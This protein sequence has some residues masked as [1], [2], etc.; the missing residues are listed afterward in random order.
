MGFLSKLFKPITDFLGDMVGFL[1]GVDFDDIENQAPAVLVNKQS[2]VAAL[3]VI[4][5]RRK[6]GGVRVYIGTG[7]SKNKYLYICLALCE[8]EIEAIESV[9]I[10][11]RLIQFDR[12]GSVFTSRNDSFYKNKIKMQKFLGTDTGKVQHATQTYSSILAEQSEWTTS[13]KLKGVAYL[14]LRVQHDSD[15]HGGIPDIKCIVKGRKVYDPRDSTTSYTNNP[16]LCLRDYLTNTRYGKGLPASAIDD[17]TGRAGFQTAADS[18]DDASYTVTPFFGAGTT[19]HL[20]ECNARLDTNKTIFSNVKEM[21][22]GMRGLMPY[23]EGKYGLIID[24]GYTP[25]ANTF[26]LTPDNITSQITVQQSGKGKR[27]NRV[28]V[29]FPNPSA[30]WQQDSVMFPEK[31]TDSNS[32]YLTFLSEDNNEELVKEVQC[33]TITSIYAARELA[34]IICLASRKNVNAVKITATSEALNIAVGD[35]VRLEHPSFGWTGAARQLMRVSNLQMQDDGEVG[36]SLVEHNNSIYGFTQGSMEPDNLESTFS[37]IFDID[38]PTGLALTETTVVGGDGSLQPAITASWTAADD[39]FVQDYEIQWKQSADSAYQ[40]AFTTETQYEIAPVQV[41]IAAPITYDVR[42]RSINTAN[43]KSDFASS[44]QQVDGDDGDPSPV[45][46]VTFTRGLKNITLEWTN[47]TDSD[48]SYVQIYISSTLTKPASPSAQVR[49]TEYVY[50]AQ[51]SEGKGTTKYFWLEAVDFSGNVSTTVGPEQEIIQLPKSEEID[52]DVSEAL[53]INVFKYPY[54]SVPASTPNTF[55]EFAIP[56]PENAVSKYASLNGKIKYIPSTSLDD[57]ILVVEFQRKSKGATSGASLGNVVASGTT[58]VPYTHYLEIS[59]NHTKEIDV[60]GG[61][62]A[63]QTSPSFVTSAKSVEY[64]GSTDRTKIIYGGN[65]ASTPN[66]TSGEMFYNDDRWT[67][68]GTWL[69]DAA[70]AQ[71]Y[72]IADLGS[73]SATLTLPLNQALAKSD[74]AEDYRVRV[75]TLGVSTGTLNL[76]EIQSQVFLL[77]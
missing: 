60:Y 69:G 25:D 66:F 72:A 45:T 37:G 22:Q 23:S 30:N 54:H 38:P 36:L 17:T 56:A 75:N 43:V 29:N 70:G 51:S 6:V 26:D 27:Y 35:V 68:S 2:N 41:N 11:D 5:G 65:S 16:A 64:L 63:S 7:G 53:S 19:V 46:G 40:V 42:V 62:A 59:G 74:S 20:L 67:S 32:D 14:A 9:Y 15:K 57:C 1:T 58:G 33:N 39:E 18:C 28:I 48:L 4:Y 55:A 44:T 61:I 76:S 31:S 8:G 49:G 73:I 12:D 71:R 24:E 3:P 21:L 34:R 50:P 13:H 77:K 47:P 10:N 52:G